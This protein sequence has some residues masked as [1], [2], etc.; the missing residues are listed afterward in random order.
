[1]FTTSGVKGNK[2]LQV[3]DENEKDNP[4]LDIEEKAEEIDKIENSNQSPNKQKFHYIIT[5]T[6]DMV[7]LPK[8]IEIRDPYPG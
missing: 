2:R 8:V 5:E 6:D 1:M 4:D 7:P 3:L